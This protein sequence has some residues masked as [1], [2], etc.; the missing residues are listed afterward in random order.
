MHTQ[1]KQINQQTED[2]GDCLS[3]KELV[4]R[5]LRNKDHR[6]SDD[7]LKKVALDCNDKTEKTPEEVATPDATSASL[8]ADTETVSDANGSDKGKDEKDV[9]ITPLD[10]IS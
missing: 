9:I 2:T 8:N 10:V 3:A 7:D 4:D 6:I 1:N 5:H